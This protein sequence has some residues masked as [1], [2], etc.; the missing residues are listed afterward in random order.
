MGGPSDEPA[1]FIDAYDYA[2]RPTT[3]KGTGMSS[4]APREA[5]LVL[6]DGSVF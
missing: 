5:L 4:T 2:F 6:A 3:P 1:S